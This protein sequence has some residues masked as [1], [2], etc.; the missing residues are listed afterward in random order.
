MNDDDIKV[1]MLVSEGIRGRHW[2]SE[3][4]TAHVPVDRDISISRTGATEGR[5]A[6]HEGRHLLT[7]HHIVADGVTTDAVRRPRT[8]RH[9]L[10]RGRIQRQTHST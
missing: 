10:Q 7:R 2:S 6:G 5:I 1:T 8:S 9:C 3:S 4:H